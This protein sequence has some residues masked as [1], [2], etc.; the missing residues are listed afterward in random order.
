MKTHLHKIGQL[1]GFL[2]KLLGLLLK[3]GLPLIGS[4]L[5]PLAKSVLFPLRLTAGGSATDAAIHKKMFGLE[6]RPSDLASRPSEL[7]FRMTALIIFNEEIN[8]IIK[9]V[10][11]LEESGSLIKGDSEKI[12]N[13]EKEQKVGFI[14]VLLGILGASLLENMLAGIGVM[15]AGEDPNRAVQYF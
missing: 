3:T 4:I 8:D 12:Q 1:G 13:E 7:T 6:R 11:S 5:K 10:K 9:I 2:G 15:I 14:G